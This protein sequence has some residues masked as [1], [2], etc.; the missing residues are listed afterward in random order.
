MDK[1]NEFLARIKQREFED[2]DKLSQYQS[3]VIE[4]TS[5]YFQ[6]SS[7]VDCSVPKT[8]RESNLFKV[9][10]SFFV[11]GLLAITIQQHIYSQKITIDKLLSGYLVSALLISV[12]VK[13]VYFGEPTIKTIIIDKSGL[14]ID[15]NAFLWDNIYE[16]AILTEGSKYVSRYLI[17]AFDDLV[18]YKK[19]ELNQFV[20]YGVKGFSVKLSNYI[21]AFKSSV[22]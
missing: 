13:Q 11:F 9:L 21:E 14:K 15:D 8:F 3:F 7:K 19:Y 2:L 1:K 5:K 12:V 16:T 17:I 6:S 18:S 22:K 20:S 10:V 4:P